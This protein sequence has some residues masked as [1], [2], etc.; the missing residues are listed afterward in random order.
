M[1]VKGGAPSVWYPVQY[2]CAA[3][4]HQPPLRGCISHPRIPQEEPLGNPEV[5][6]QVGNLI[7][8][9]FGGGIA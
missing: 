1:L 4:R 5:K 2:M 9:K 3:A 6:G 7:D 8:P